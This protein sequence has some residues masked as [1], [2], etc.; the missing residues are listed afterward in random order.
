MCLSMPVWADS[1]DS[2]LSRAYS[3]FDLQ[4]QMVTKKTS[5]I[6]QGDGCIEE[7]LFEQKI[8]V[9]GAKM[10]EALPS[11]ALKESKVPQFSFEVVDKATPG[12]ISNV[13]GKIIVFRGVQYMHLS[14]DALSFALAREMGH[15]MAGHNHSNVMTKLFF[16]ALTTL[17]FPVAGLVSSSTATSAATSVSG[18][19]GSNAVINQRKAQQLKEAD[20]IALKLCKSAGIDALAMVNSLDLEGLE[21]NAW[22]LDLQKTKTSISE[23]LEAPSVNAT[24][25]APDANSIH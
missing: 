22:V 12:M 10:V 19:V 3:N 18:M 13:S 14:D 1:D 6:C 16:T 20:V 2:S 11:V 8:E 25:T 5:A 23:T 4:M 15:I 21:S 9:L 7:Q 24:Q 17:I